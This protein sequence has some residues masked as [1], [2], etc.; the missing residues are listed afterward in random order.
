MGLIAAARERPFKSEELFVWTADSRGA[1]QAAGDVFVRL[2]A[3]DPVGQ[4]LGPL[5]APMPPLDRPAAALTRHTAADGGL[6]WAMVFT[7]PVAGGVLGVG[8]KPRERA[9]F[10]DEVAARRARRVSG[11]A[12]AM[13][14]RELLGRVSMRLAT[15]ARLAE[16]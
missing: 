11:E 13:G 2:C 15:H 6:F 8:F 5:V 4:P 14:L 3:A 16:T 10:V 1:I 12:T 7:L 9:G